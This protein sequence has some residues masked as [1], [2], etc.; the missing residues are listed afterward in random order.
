MFIETLIN[1]FDNAF[2]RY[3]I[4]RVIDNDLLKIVKS[5][6]DIVSKD[7]L[8]H[9]LSFLNKLPQSKHIEVS[10][11]IWNYLFYLTIDKDYRDSKN[12]FINE[13][14]G[15]KEKAI[16][17]LIPSDLG[18]AQ[19]FKE[20]INKVFTT[21]SIHSKGTNIMGTYSDKNKFKEL[22]YSES[23]STKASNQKK[24]NIDDLFEIV[25][26]IINDL[27]TKEF[28]FISKNIYHN[29]TAIMTK[30]KFTIYLK[31]ICKANKINNY[32]DDIRDF[33][34]NLK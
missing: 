18:H 22:T 12:S 11:Q 20:L 30:E 1:E 3:Y 8:I 33:I 15:G 14:R 26:L 9:Y 21:Y 34:A 6:E 28:K 32:T 2:K 17:D 4:G 7:D 23:K 16:K 5:Y 24:Y 13:N 27:E 31:S 25:D 19:R 10:S 29:E